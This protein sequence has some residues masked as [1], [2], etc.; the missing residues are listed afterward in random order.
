[1]A[2]SK[3]ELEKTKAELEKVKAASPLQAKIGKIVETF[4][5]ETT[6]DYENK[7]IINKSEG[8]FQIKL[9]PVS[10]TT[11]PKETKETTA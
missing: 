1:M 3:A 4:K 10:T 11:P 7:Y 8:G 2:A 9:K 6:Y 5:K